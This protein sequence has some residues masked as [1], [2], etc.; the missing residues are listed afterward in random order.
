MDSSSTVFFRFEAGTVTATSPPGTH[1]AQLSV[2]PGMTRKRSSTSSPRYR[3]QH[4]T[5]ARRPNL[6]P[7]S[8]T[9]SETRQDSFRLC[10][11]SE[12]HHHHH[13]IH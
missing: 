1:R 10:R 4:C 5:W 3:G 6:P 8:A 11:A 13:H 2:S 12:A 9:C 7:V